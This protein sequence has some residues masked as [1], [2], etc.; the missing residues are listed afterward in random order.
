MDSVYIDRVGAF[1]SLGNAIPDGIKEGYE[2][3]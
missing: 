2:E 3:I 1:D